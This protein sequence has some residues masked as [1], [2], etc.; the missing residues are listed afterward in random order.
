MSEPALLKYWKEIHS[1]YWV[2]KDYAGRPLATMQEMRVSTECQVL[3]CGVK[4]GVCWGG[5]L[6]A[7]SSRY[8]QRAMRRARLK[9][10][11]LAESEFVIDFNAI[12]NGVI[13]HKADYRG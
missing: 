12:E 10:M 7:L 1:G 2:L 8:R 9:L 5:I 13:K 6:T 3:R 4:Y 11:K